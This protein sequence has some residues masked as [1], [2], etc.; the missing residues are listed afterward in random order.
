MAKKYCLLILFCTMSSSV[1]IRAQTLIEGFSANNVSGGWDL[2]VGTS[3]SKTGE[4]LYLWEKGGRVFVCN[5]NSSMNM[6]EKQTTPVIDISPEVGNWRDMGLLGFAL[7]PQFDQNGFIYLM[8]CVDRHHLIYYGTPQYNENINDYLSATIGR[9]TRYTTNV[10]SIGQRVADP[11]SRKIL[12]GET[13]ETGIPILY[14]S[15]GVGTLA[16]AMDGTLLAS[17][18]DGSSYAS[19]DTGSDPDTYYAQALID[20]II[21]ENENVGSFRSQMLN[22]HS[23][24][25]LRIDPAT[26][27][28]VPSNPFYDPQQPRSAKSRVW[29]M[30]FRNPFRFSIRPNSGSVDPGLG[31]IGELFISD[32]GFNSFE[33]ITVIRSPGTNCGWPLYEGLVYDLDYGNRSV[34]N[35][36][37]PNPLYGSGSC[38]KPYFTFRQLLRQANP[39][40]NTAVYNPCNPS[41]VIVSQNNSRF[42]HRPP[43]LDWQHGYDVAR[44][45]IFSG[46]TFLA[47]TIG[48]QESQVSGQ[49]FRG[50]A[51]SASLWYTGN[52]FPSTYKNTLFISDFGANWIKN[53]HLEYLEKPKQ[54]EN[55]AFDFNGIVHMA[56]NPMDGSIYCVDIGAQMIKRI[57]FVSNRPPV[58]RISVD[59]N[60]GPSPVNISF[61]AADS[62]D[63]EALPLQFEWDFGDGS[64][65]SSEPSPIHTFTARNGLPKKYTVKL[66]VTDNQSEVAFDSIIISVNN[67]PPQ[68]SIISPERNW[69]YKVGADTTLSLR[70]EVSDLE[71]TESMLS[72]R[73]Q[74]ILR[75]NNHE[76]PDPVDTSKSTSSVISRIGCNGETFH[77]FIKLSV[78]DGHGLTSYDS[79]KLYPGCATQPPVLTTQPQSRV[80]CDGEDVLFESGTSDYFILPVQWQVSRDSGMSWT[81]I[82]GAT[83][84]SL[85]IKA[86]LSDN[87]ARY[88]ALWSN[89]KGSS[90]SNTAVI[91]VNSIPPVPAGADTLKFCFA[92]R[93]ADMQ[94]EGMSL[95]WYSSNKGGEPLPSSSYLA[96]GTFYYAS[97]ILN[98]CESKERLRVLVS[99]NDAVHPSIVLNGERSVGAPS[100]YRWTLINGPN[101]PVID[102][103]NSSKTTVRGLVEGYYRFRLSLNEGA[104]ESDVLALVNV[105]DT[106]LQARA[107]FDRSIILPENSIQLDGS[108]STGA[109]DSIQWRDLATGTSTN[110]SSPDSVATLV[111][112][113]TA[114]DHPFELTIRDS[115]G[116]SSKDTVLVRVLPASTDGE[117][118]VVVAV[119]TSY[120]SQAT[121]SCQLSG[122]P[123]G[124]MLVLTIANSNPASS[125]FNPS[126]TLQPDPQNLYND[127]NSIELGMKFRSAEDGYI[128]GVRFFKAVGNT[129]IH[130]GE[131]YTADGIRLAQA[132][133]L[134]ETTS[135]WQQVNF[136][137][138]VR[139]QKNTTYIVAYFSTQGYYS[140]VPDFFN[141]SVIES[142]LT[143]LASGIDGANGLY[144]YTNTPSFPASSY[145]KAN[146]WVDAVFISAEP[147]IQSEPAL[148]WV[149]RAAADG[150]AGSGNA[151]VYTALFP[152][153]GNVS[154]TASWG[155]GPVSSSLYGIIGYDNTLSGN[156]ADTSALS[157]VNISLPSSRTNSLLIG[158][159]SDH[160][161]VAADSRQYM[162]GNVETGFHFIPG[163]Y[164]GYHFTKQAAQIDSYTLGLTKPTGMSAGIAA[165]EV[166][167]LIRLPVIADAGTNQRRSLSIAPSGETM[168]SFCDT[169]MVQDL[170]VKGNEVKWHLSDTG[171]MILGPGI[172]LVDSNYYYASQVVNG[173]SSSQR[174]KVLA[175][176]TPSPLKPTVEVKDNCDS[177]LT[178]SVIPYGKYTW[179]TG[180]TGV[181]VKVAT[182]DTFYVFRTENGCAGD[183]AFIRSQPVL[184]R[185]EADVTKPLCP[186]DSGYVKLV[187]RGGAGSYVFNGPTS[188]YFA[189]GTYI[190][191]VKDTNNCTR[192]IEV[193]I[194]VER[195]YW[196]GTVDN[197]WHNAAN[198]SSGQ[199]PSGRTHVII[200]LTARQCVVSRQD[201]EA[202]SIQT[203]QGGTIRVDNGMKVLVAGKC[204]DLPM[205]Y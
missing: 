100:S 19:I 145:G 49:P 71:H 107:G 189:S 122:L 16:F 105:F 93:I 61:S 6:Y 117:T 44:T 168:Q 59:K 134:N 184:L 72:Y 27:N 65:R 46:D 204:V 48:T 150:I 169:A 52:M 13:K 180:D 161:A 45:G 37:E 149:K 203:V 121:T 42:L 66:K 167:G 2:P 156:S 7:D 77:W 76:H 43:L 1:A 99:V 153:G 205:V 178:F 58:A 131:L 188:G 26:G 68:V 28:G 141:T 113:L 9:I 50:N 152:R 140:A 22:S 151:A 200:P 35:K 124:S 202:A 5:W 67:T 106:T 18:G 194:E 116:N 10:N 174:L 17:A 70:A 34:E 114:G 163:S 73:W 182:S 148:S 82:P 11:A 109:I 190:F 15:H 91:K 171:G 88:R 137:K 179:S 69:F 87:G 199:V 85:R 80:L 146:Y 192:Q 12:L 103:P 157:S 187:A 30:G 54:V 135:G 143:A 84:P 36:D 47:A 95:K 8:Y 75:H 102:S 79:V 32:V 144:S 201:A 127:G 186:G 154:V 98:G 55:F 118:P 92:A 74:T 21:R 172:S 94:M 193:V 159:A 86:K 104:S 142:P 198:W 138:P 162:T 23:G 24:K 40:E 53:V 89:N 81:S 115:L 64:L 78:T 185:L 197:D 129:G 56:E 173:C 62:Y 126:Q 136:G 110:F 132:T 196:T 20:K 155:K 195:S 25:L 133:F 130:I 119:D 176:V 160:N 158:V 83:A 108:A 97:Q 165:L 112:I 177:S 101:V 125:V 181:S 90:Y 14:E 111:S 170:V 139:I 4:Q 31:D 96:D 166:K 3:F 51:A 183:T 123:T 38:T 175:L 191:S 39:Q 128:A 60:F 29:A 33:E 57:S 63:P 120:G 41:Q 164:T 147:V